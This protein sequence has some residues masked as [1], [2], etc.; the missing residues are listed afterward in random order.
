LFRLLTFL[1]NVDV[2]MELIWVTLRQSTLMLTV[3]T[4][5]SLT[6]FVLFGCLVYVVEQGTFT[7]NATYPNGAYLK[8][9]DDGTGTTVSNILSAVQG[10]YW[11]I[12]TGTGNGTC[13]TSPWLHLNDCR[14]LPFM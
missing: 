8:P 10:L 5:F 9:N 7:V 2:A 6:V 4:C 11:A 3:S 13:L 12:L 14:L 1:K